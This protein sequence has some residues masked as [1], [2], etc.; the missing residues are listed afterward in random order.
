MVFISERERERE[1][2]RESER[3]R[4]RNTLRPIGRA[5]EQLRW[6]DRSDLRRRA[7][8]EGPATSDDGGRRATTTGER[9]TTTR[10]GAA[11]VTERAAPASSGGATV[12]LVCS[13]FRVSFLLC[14]L[15]LFCSVFGFF[16]F[17]DKCLC[18]AVLG[19]GVWFVF[20]LYRVDC[21]DLCQRRDRGL[22]SD[23]LCYFFIFLFFGWES[24]GFATSVLCWA[25]R[26][27]RGQKWSCNFIRLHPV[28]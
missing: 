9:G 13:G 1:R 14:I 23:L 12:G 15:F 22:I 16:F 17:F 19:N 25:F 26:V 5:P 20:A 24:M 3:K 18:I 21:L 4:G 27:C 11:E 7:S 8:D 2:E 10:R 28:Y 6:W